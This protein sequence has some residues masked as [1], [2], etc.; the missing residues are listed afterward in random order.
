MSLHPSLVHMDQLP[1][2]MQEEPLA[3]IGDDPRIHASTEHG[4]NIV[5]I[6]LEMMELILQEELARL[7]PE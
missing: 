7:S 5:N 6:H 3:L 4:D 2:D 1:E